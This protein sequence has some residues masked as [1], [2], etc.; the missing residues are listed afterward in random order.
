[1]AGAAL[2]HHQPLL[3]KIGLIDVERLAEHGHF[4]HRSVVIE[5]D[6]ATPP[7]WSGHHPEIDNDPCKHLGLAGRLQVLEAR[8]DEAL[9]SWPGGIEGVT[10]QVEAEHCLL[11]GEALLVG[12]RRALD[13]RLAWRRHWVVTEQAGLVGVGFGLLCGLHR[14]SDRRDHGRPLAVQGVERAAADQRLNGAAVGQTAVDPQAEVEQ[15]GER[16]GLAARG[17][18]TQDRALAHAL[19]A[20]ESVAHLVAVD[21]HEAVVGGVDV[22]RQDV[23]AVLPCILE[24]HA[25]LV[26]VVHR[27]THVGGG[28][29]GGVVRL[30]VGGLV[31]HQCVGGGVRLVEAV[32]GKALHQVEQLGGPGLRHAVLGRTFSKG[33]TVRGHLLGLLLAHGTAQQ[34]GAAQRVAADHL[35]DLH[36]LFLVDHDAVGLAKDRLEPLVEVFDALLAMFALDEVGD[37]VHRP[38]TVERHQRDDVLEAVRLG[39]LEHVLHAARFELEH[40]GG[41]GAGQKVEGRTVVE[42]DGVEVEAGVAASLDRQRPHGL[43]GGSEDGQGGQA[44]EVELD[45]TGRLDIV[46]VE[47]TYRVAALGHVERA[48]VGQFAGCDEYAAGVHADVADGALQ[49]FGQRQQLRGLLVLCFAGLDLRALFA[50]VEG[51]LVV[52]IGAAAQRY[53]LAGQVGHQLDQ[54][55]GAVVAPLQH[56]P[57][58]AQHG[59]CG[60][61]AE[62]GDLRHRFLAVLLAHIVDD[63]V[64]PL[65]TEVDVEVGHGYPLR[66]EK[67]LEQQVVAQRVEVGDTETVGHQRAR[68][69]AASGAHR[70]AVV[71]GP[72][73]EVGDDQEVA[74]ETHLDDRLAF[75]GEPLAVARALRFALGR[76]SEALQ[77]TALQ[78]GLRFGDQVL[79]ERHAGWGREQWQP[80]LA[81]CQHEVAAPCDLDGVLQ[82]LRQIGEA[83]QHLCLAGEVLLRR[84]YA[85]TPSVGQHLPLGDA[86][87][88][89]MRPEIVGGEELNRMGGDQRQVQGAGQ[90]RCRAGM[91]LRDG[92]TVALRF[93]VESAREACR[94]LAGQRRRRV[95][96]A[97]EQRA[98][99]LAVARAAQHD[100]A[101]ERFGVE[102]LT[103]QKGPAALH[104]LAVGAG[105]QPAERQIAGVVANQQQQAR[106]VTI[107]LASQPQVGPADRLDPGCARG[108]VELDQAEQ[109]AEVG[110]RQRGLVIGARG[111]D[112]LLDA[113]GAISHR[114]FAVQ[115][116][117]DEARLRHAGFRWHGWVQERP[118]ILQWAPP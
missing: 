85:R 98:A 54:L 3:A 11:C 30:H 42:R 37:E 13:Q 36:H 15:A 24:K 65:L 102:P 43:L 82:C 22:R 57:D 88:R 59:A 6:Q 113:R 53:R 68:A 14:Q 108:F 73:D 56:A 19:D 69:G 103:A 66:V 78:T 118:V 31:G 105:H 28:E 93:E 70:H 21:R 50:G 96:L 115:S 92:G 32:A 110:Q 26:G 39:A 58:I 101:A 79:V 111:R 116:Q 91:S 8:L 106:A 60:H 86:D 41:V 33:D 74:G 45:Q 2:D 61:G 47:L 109:I 71:L 89:L 4:H 20:A 38:R 107:A 67:T 10:G 90:P 9:Q 84:V 7:A 81:E 77:Q 64:A 55:I 104:A 94:P 76:V 16:P 99:D 117:M 1:M 87:A 95:G 75:E 44:E 114:V 49:L 51:L 40:S 52:G 72:A 12:P 48:K 63:P 27:R 83:L 80:R 97:T 29:G 100:Q 18:Q 34:V 23:D 35:R 5:S 17:H 112:R 25:Q 62:G 46:L